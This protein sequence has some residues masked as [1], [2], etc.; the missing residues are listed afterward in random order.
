MGQKEKLGPGSYNFKDFLEELQS[1]PGSTRGLLSSGEIRFRGLI[2]VGVLILEWEPSHSLLWSMHLAGAGSTPS[3]MGSSPGLA[4]LSS[5]TPQPLCFQCH[6]FEPTGCCRVIFSPPPDQELPDGKKG[7]GS[8]LSHQHKARYTVGRQQ[9]HPSLQPSTQQIMMERP[10][11]PHTVLGPGVP[12]VTMTRSLPSWSCGPSGSNN[13]AKK[14][15]TYD[16]SHEEK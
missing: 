9:T 8:S 1:K 13:S 4:R 2:G 3:P 5:E 11:V 10:L 15:I 7:S 16:L 6:I 14:Q 12:A